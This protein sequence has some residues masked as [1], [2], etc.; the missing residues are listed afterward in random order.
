[1]LNPQHTE[2]PSLLPLHYTTANLPNL[3]TFSLPIFLNGAKI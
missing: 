2:L 1:M 3:L